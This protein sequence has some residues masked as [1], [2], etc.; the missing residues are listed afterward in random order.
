M[1]VPQGPGPL[2]PVRLGLAG[3]RQRPPPLA[4]VVHAVE[5]LG[6]RIAQVTLAGEDLAEFQWPGPASHLKLVLAAG[7]TDPAVVS[8]TYTP[9]RF[10]RARGLL[11]LVFALHGHGPGASWAAQ[12]VAGD[13]VAVTRPRPRANVGDGVAWLLLAGDESAL[14]AI[15]TILD[16]VPSDLPVQVL[17]EVE[18][19]HDEIDLSAGGAVTVDWLHRGATG[20]PGDELEAAIG[21]WRRPGGDGAVWSAG[22]ASSIRRVRR[23]LIEHGLPPRRLVT[24]GYW[25]VGEADHP[26]HDDGD[27]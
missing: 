18:G 25:R 1:T 10:D 20:R 8:R 2:D 6:P 26:D 13:E 7:G 11:D 17:V 15:G 14:P 19:R 16:S 27:D 23:L 9:R 3:R 21:G 5:R 4:V 22:E 12:A 24:R